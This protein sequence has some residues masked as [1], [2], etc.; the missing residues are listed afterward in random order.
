MERIVE[1]KMDFFDLR[2]MRFFDC[3]FL[4]SSRGRWIAQTLVFALTSGGAS[5]GKGLRVLDQGCLEVCDDGF[6][7]LWRSGFWTRFWARLLNGV[8]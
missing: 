6:N 5:L 3:N 7:P 8:G 1:S 4:G 2:K